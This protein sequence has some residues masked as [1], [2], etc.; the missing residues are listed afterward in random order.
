[1]GVGLRP[2]NIGARVKR[3]ED[4]RLLTGEGAFTGDREVLGALHIAFRRSDHPYALISEIS[5][6]GSP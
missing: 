5:T 1:V 4:R 3:V 2:K 6:A